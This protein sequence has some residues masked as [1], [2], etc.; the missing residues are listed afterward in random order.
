MSVTP[1]TSIPPILPRWLTCRLPLR[2]KTWLFWLRVRLLYGG[3]RLRCNI[4]RQSF[5]RMLPFD[6]SRRFHPLGVYLRKSYADCFCPYCYSSFRHRLF[7]RVMEGRLGE[8]ARSQARALR[9]LH[10]APEHHLRPLLASLP[11]VEYETADP[12]MPDVDRKLDLTNLQLGDGSRDVIIAI[13][14][15]EHIADHHAAISEIFRVLSP[16]GMAAI[17]V[18][19]FGTRTHEDS[20]LVSKEDRVRYFGQANHVIAFGMDLQHVF[21]QYGFSV[22]IIHHRDVFQEKE[23]GGSHIED[24]EGWLF[25]ATKP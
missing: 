22:E 6:G 9:V 5:R 8:L 10:F 17:M 15:L 2:I 23:C 4:C 12:L 1:L 13:H 18:P 3:G 7:W 25:L 21:V 19:V 11:Y 24:V 14:V 16:G 20:S